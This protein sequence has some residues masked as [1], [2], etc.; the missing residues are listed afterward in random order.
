[1]NPMLVIFVVV[2]DL[3]TSVMRPPYLDLVP[4]QFLR[5]LTGAAEATF[6]V[7]SILDPSVPAPSLD[8][9]P[10]PL[11]V[12]DTLCEEGPI[13]LMVDMSPIT[14]FESAYCFDG[15]STGPMEPAPA[16]ERPV[17]FGM[18]LLLFTLF[19][20]VISG[21]K[22]WPYIVRFPRDIYTLTLSGVVG[23]LTRLLESMPIRD[24]LQRDVTVMI[25]ERTGTIMALPLISELV[26]I[27]VSLD[28]DPPSTI[29]TEILEFDY[30]ALVPSKG[31]QF[32]IPAID[33]LGFHSII[34]NVIDR[35]VMMVCM[36]SV[37]A[38]FPLAN[39]NLS[40]SDND[41]TENDTVDG[42]VN[43]VL[44]SRTDALVLRTID[45]VSQL[46]FMAAVGM[47]L[48]CWEI[49][50]TKVLTTVVEREKGAGDI[51]VDGPHIC[52]VTLDLIDT[53]DYCAPSRKPF[54]P[55]AES[56][57]PEFVDLSG[58]CHPLGSFDLSDPSD[59]SVP[60]EPIEPSEATG[61]KKRLG[62]NQRRKLLKRAEVV[63]SP[64]EEEKR[65][66]EAE[67]K[68]FAAKEN[69][70]ASIKAS[71]DAVLARV[72]HGPSNNQPKGY[73]QYGYGPTAYGLPPRT[74]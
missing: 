38:D 49:Q 37:K 74:W 3:W 59:L 2:F 22:F 68:I 73:G 62:K 41:D 31:L 28:M 10:D 35:L 12:Y 1:M 33:V 67:K 71:Q 72:N 20:V 46:A 53:S 56:S 18:V 42:D 4:I 44:P 60:S 29:E 58:P 61:K 50:Q 25:D 26:S 65:S 15:Y 55:R 8:L 70:L 14:T 21:F 40:A 6:H 51:E 27:F 54:R 66:R 45:N 5:T 64:T 52:P 13:D 9:L 30:L 48:A 69:E 47:L 17:S 11:P 7:L 32:S 24:R 57:P 16:M 23:T 39:D 43:S 19:S 63:K 36:E 34:D